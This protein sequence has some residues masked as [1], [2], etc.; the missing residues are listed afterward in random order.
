MI[1]EIFIKCKDCI[2]YEECNDM[3]VKY[4]ETLFQQKGNWREI[5]ENGKRVKT[6]IRRCAR[7]ITIVHQNKFKNKKILEIGCGP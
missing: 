2:S 6:P 4:R 7:S 1:N 3:E 5:Y